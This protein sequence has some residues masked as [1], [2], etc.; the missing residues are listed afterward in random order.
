MLP[1]TLFLQEMVQTETVSI[2][3]GLIC[4]LIG[5]IWADFV[6]PIGDFGYLCHDAPN[7]HL[8]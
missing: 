3:F 1:I 2:H 6:R 8:T 7:L 5:I 4:G